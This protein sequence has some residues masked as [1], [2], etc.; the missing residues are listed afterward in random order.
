MYATYGDRGPREAV[1][2]GGHHNFAEDMLEAESSRLL[3]EAVDDGRGA[4]FGLMV[5]TKGRR[6]LLLVWC[7][8]ILWLLLVVTAISAEFWGSC[9]FESGPLPVC[10]HCMAQ[11][12]LL[13]NLVLVV[14]WSF[15][16]Y[17]S[18]LLASRGFQFGLELVE[19][20]AKGI[21]RTATQVF[22]YLFTGMIAW[23]AMG[24]I[25]LVYSSSCHVT[26]GALHTYSR[27][28]LLALSTGVSLLIAPPSL[29]LGRCQ[30]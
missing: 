17:L 4:I 7:T 3:S 23:L 1:N 20:E 18:I 12:F 15:H 13:W 29:F 10:R 21:P 6:W 30:L 25:L 11:S 5:H 14:L 8:E 28:G 27:S 19:N 22:I 24:G 9:P 16:L 26:G 2:L